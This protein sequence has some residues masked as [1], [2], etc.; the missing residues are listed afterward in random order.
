MFTWD[1]QKALSNFEKHG[2]SFEEAC[3]VFE[4]TD[5]LHGDDIK[6]SDREPRYFAVGLSSTRRVLTVVYT[7]S[8]L[9]DGKET[10][11]I[12][13]ARQASKQERKAYA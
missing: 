7:V 11:R 4:D 3:L 2:V 13:S 9:G 5:A 1:I 12:I 6:H 10:I 8:R